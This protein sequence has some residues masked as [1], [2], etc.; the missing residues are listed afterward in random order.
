MGEK[1]NVSAPIWPVYNS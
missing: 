1:M